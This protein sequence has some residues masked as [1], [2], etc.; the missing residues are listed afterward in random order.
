MIPPLSIRSISPLSDR[1][2]ST[3]NQNVN[4]HHVNRHLVQTSGSAPHADNP[5]HP[6]T[7]LCG[8]VHHD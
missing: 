7:E 6:T 2:T 4:R 3:I 1:T 8:S 5:F